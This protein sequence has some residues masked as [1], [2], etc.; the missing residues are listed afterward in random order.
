M[1]HPVPLRTSVVLYTHLEAGLCCAG[2]LGHSLIKK[3][4]K[5]GTRASAI[6]Q[7]KDLAVRVSSSR[8][9]FFS[10]EQ[11]SSSDLIQTALS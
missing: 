7:F 2:P 3:S 5:F 11:V 9:I 8:Y 10:L 1:V 6:K 4:V